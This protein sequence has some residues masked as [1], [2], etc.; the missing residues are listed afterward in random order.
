MCGQSRDTEMSE[1]KG[2]YTKHVK[3]NLMIRMPLER[4]KRP[5]KTIFK[6]CKDE[7]LLPD[8]SLFKCPGKPCAIEIKWD[9]S[10]SGLR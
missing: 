1:N 5:W 6:E 4:I 2:T 7:Q 3:N 8:P 10:A 9:T